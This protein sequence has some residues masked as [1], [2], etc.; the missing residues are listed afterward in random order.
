MRVRAHYSADSFGE[1]DTSATTF[2]VESGPEFPPG[3]MN[4]DSVVDFGDINPFVL[5]LSNPA[6]YSAAYPACD[7]ANGDVNGDES[8]DFGDINPFVGLLSGPS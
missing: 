5:A 7:I 1:W 8:V 6:A 4:C 3:D 2:V